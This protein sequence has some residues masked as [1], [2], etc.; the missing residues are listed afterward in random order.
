MSTRQYKNTQHTGTWRLNNRKNLR[1]ELD[2]QL[3]NE[4]KTKRHIIKTM[5][6]TQ[7]EELINGIIRKLKSVKASFKDTFDYDNFEQMIK[8]D[9]LFKSDNYKI[10]I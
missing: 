6:K 3:D 4:N 1:K 7:K 9:R 8:R 10:F 2:K 5:T